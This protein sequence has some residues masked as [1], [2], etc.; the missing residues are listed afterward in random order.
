MSL[1]LYTQVRGTGPDL[2]LLHGWG[3]NSGVWEPISHSLTDF[4][5]VTM[6]DLPGFGRNCDAM[7]EVYDLATIAAMVSEYVPVHSHLL[8][9]SLGGLVAQKIAIEQPSLLSSLM[10]L[11]STPKFAKEQNWP[12]IK[13]PVLNAFE[14]QLER[15]FTKTLE[16]FMA[17]QAMGSSTA[18]HDIKQIKT[19]IQHYPIPALAALRAGLNI[20]SVSDLRHQ[21]STIKAPTLRMY[22]RLDS[23]VPL[24]ALEAVAQL[25]PN[26][27]SYVFA[28]ASH[29]PFISHPDEFVERVTA[30]VHSLTN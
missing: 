18:K 28:H 11:A 22:G 5:R 16:R 29:A 12:G 19:H 15:D 24:A 26:S 20:L 4:F 10:V 9:W 14:Q 25:H 27:E 6:I 21:L 7:P 1:A 8:G 3:L 30:F 13:A 2:V 17:I 23:L